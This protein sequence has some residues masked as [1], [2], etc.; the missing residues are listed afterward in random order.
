V[1]V[2]YAQI[3]AVMANLFDNAAR[4]CPPAT[5]LRV[6]ATTS[7]SRVLVVV[8]DDGPGIAPARRGEVLRPFRS[9]NTGSSGLGLAIC[10]GIVAAHGGTL[11]IGETPGG[12]TRISFGLPRQS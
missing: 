11:E 1:L 7:P 3:D 9:G 5:T 10:R 12:G 8:S 4:H 6:S 2:D